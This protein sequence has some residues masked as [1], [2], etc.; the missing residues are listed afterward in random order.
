MTHVAQDSNVIRGYFPTVHGL[1]RIE[2]C[3]HNSMVSPF[4]CQT[5]EYSF[6]EFSVR[7]IKIGN[8]PS[9]FS[10]VAGSFGVHCT[11][12]GGTLVH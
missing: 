9:C 2:G 12:F 11:R 8:L 1:H 3:V 7:Y 4:L 5:L 6:A 10:T